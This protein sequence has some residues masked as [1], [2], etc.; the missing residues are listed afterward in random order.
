MNL[1]FC[2]WLYSMRRGQVFVMFHEV[3]YRFARAQSVRRNGLAA[4]THLM[5]MLVARRADRIFVSIPGWADFLKRWTGGK[6]VRWLPVPS[7]L[8]VVSC[9]DR[10]AMEIR[11]KYCPEGGFLLGHFGTYGPLIADRL[12]ECLHALLEKRPGCNVLLLGRNSRAFQTRFA[13]SAAHLAGRVHALGGLEGPELARCA[14][15]C[16]LMIQPYPDGVSSRR[17]S[18][19]FALSNG[20]PVV[21]NSGYL[22]EPLWK[23]R[24]AVAM[25]P[26]FDRDSIIDVALQLMSNRCQLRS[27]RDRSRRLYSDLFDIKWTLAE[28]RKE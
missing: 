10:A 23:E 20:I 9:A 15:A 5:A 3:W 17:G 13:G 19:M 16:D 26:N 12:E 28:L 8:P 2:M 11:P 4:A 24:G 18:V 6:T 21:T 22:T 7:N 27:L 1:P 14:G 25:A